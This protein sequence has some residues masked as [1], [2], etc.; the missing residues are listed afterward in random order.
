MKFIVIARIPL[1]T[2]NAAVRDGSAGEKTDRILQETKPE[3]VYFTE[4]D[5]LRTVVMAVEMTNPSQ[6][7]FFA[8]PWFLNFGCRVEFHPAMTQEDLRNAGLDNLGKH[9]G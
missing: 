4:M 9:W 7:P 6:I 3:A 5:G 2:F 1:E 8:E